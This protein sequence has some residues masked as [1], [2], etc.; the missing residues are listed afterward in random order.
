MVSLRLLLKNSKPGII[1]VTEFSQEAALIKQIRHPRVVQVYGV[2]TQEEPIYVIIELMKH[3][4]LLEYLRGDGQS[5]KL[6]QLIDMGAQVAAGM[7]YLEENNYI[8]GLCDNGKTYI[9][10]MFCK[11]ISIK[12]VISI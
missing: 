7:A 5:L 6:P 11:I 8:L 1:S 10:I 9:S 3:G 4:S 2:C 12:V